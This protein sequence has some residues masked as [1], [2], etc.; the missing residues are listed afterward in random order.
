MRK[1][2]TVETSW[3]YLKGILMMFPN[4]GGYESQLAITCNPV[5]LPV[6]GLS[7]WLKGGP[8]EIPKQPAGAQTKGR[9]LRIDSGAPLPKTPPT[10]LTENGE[11]ELLPTWGLQSYVPVPLAWEGTLQATKKGN[12]DTNP[13]T[14]PLNYNLSCLKSMLGKWRQRTRG[15]SQPT[16]DF[17]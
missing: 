17:T 4:N 16:S 14:R 3:N 9:I 5:R 15:S 10:Q 6:V 2:S 7:C 8:M 13:A 12:T 11:I 1:P